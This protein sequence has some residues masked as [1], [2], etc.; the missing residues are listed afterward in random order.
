MNSPRL[1]SLLFL[2]F[3]L[4][5]S[6]LSHASSEL[7]IVVLGDSLTAGYGLPLQAA[8]PARL[9]AALKQR[10][11]QVRV[12]NAGVSG[13]T[14]MGGLARL[15]WA[16]ADR[17]DL[18]IVELGA[19]D[20]LRGLSPQQTRQNLSSILYRLRDKGVQ[21]L[22][23]GMKA[24]PSMGEDYYSKFDRIYPELAQ[25]HQVPLYPFFL[26]GVAG[27]PGLNQA[28]G[29]HPTAAGIDVIVSG[30]L[31]LVEKTLQRLSAEN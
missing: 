22:L 20:A 30:I 13:D 18:M 23:A 5:C 3:S 16:L 26:E 31:P 4:C 29:I 19:N 24:P 6:D 12:F 1:I 14:S 11:Y 2:F 17:P 7:R 10:N 8:F 27:V 25:Q 28:D 9:E 15:D 21:A